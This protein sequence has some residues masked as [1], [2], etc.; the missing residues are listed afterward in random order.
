MNNKFLLVFIFLIFFIIPCFVYKVYGAIDDYF[1]ED[2]DVDRILSRIKNIYTPVIKKKIGRKLVVKYLEGVSFPT[3]RAFLSDDSKEAVVLLTAG[4]VKHKSVTMDALAL[5][6]CHEIGHHIGGAPFHTKERWASSE[7]QADYFATLKCFREFARYDDNVRL[8]ENKMVPK[9]AENKCK[10]SFYNENEVAICKRSI[11]AALSFVDFF[12][13]FRGFSDK[14]SLSTP[15][16]YVTLKSLDDYPE[17]QCRLDTFFQGAICSA[18]FSNSLGNYSD[19]GVC[20]RGSGE[21]KS[22]Y[23]PLCWYRPAHL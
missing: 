21:Y 10:D 13:V 17:P 23:R 9:I 14:V 20:Y 6:I 3:A 16:P 2:K 7:G 11:M 4:V 1:I 8:M 22:G 15:S 19:I 5:I 12:I 18:N